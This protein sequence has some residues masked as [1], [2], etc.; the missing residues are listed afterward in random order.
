MATRPKAAGESGG[1]DPYLAGINVPDFM[2]LEAHELEALLHLLRA[3]LACH[4]YLLLKTNMVFKTGEFLG[5][6]ARLMD[7][8]T[9]PA[10][11]R[12][13]RPSGPTYKQ[14]RTALDALVGV[15]LVQRSK[16][17]EDQGQ[18]RLR[19]APLGSSSAAKTGQSAN[20]RQVH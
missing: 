11:E 6:Y 12:G 5:S 1:R 17:N 13:R 14:C 20:V 7:L 15:G 3:P 4:L 19:L 2:Y 16:H 9:P 8:M 10:P 18:L